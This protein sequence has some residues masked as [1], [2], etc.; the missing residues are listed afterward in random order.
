MSTRLHLEV[1]SYAVDCFL[2]RNDLQKRDVTMH[3][4]IAA[5]QFLHP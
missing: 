5:P 4:A 2:L 1:R 3:D